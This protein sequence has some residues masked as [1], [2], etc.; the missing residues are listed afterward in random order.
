MAAF[1]LAPTDS[2]SA[3]CHTGYVTYRT[4][5]RIVWLLP[6]FLLLPASVRAQD[7]TYTTNVGAITITGY[8]GAGGDVVIPDTIDGLPVTDIGTRAFYGNTSLTSVLIPVSVTNISNSAF[9]AC[10]NLSL[11]QLGDNARTIG[12]GAFGFCWSLTNVTIP[13]CVTTIGDSA[14]LGCGGLTSV[15]IPK[16][17]V[18]IGTSAFRT[19]VQG[20]RSLTNIS[21]D[22][23]NP[24]Y[25]S[26][27]GVLFD[28]TQTILI[29]CP[30][31]K[32]GNYPIPDGVTDIGYDSFAECVK[33]VSITIPIGVTNIGDSAFVACGGLTSVSI[34]D[35]V[36]AIGNSAFQSCIGLTNVTIGNAVTT[37]GDSAFVNC[38]GLTS[39]SIPDSVFAIGTNVFVSC[40][41]L[42]DIEVN[43]A[44]PNFS[45]LDGVLFDKAEATLLLY[46]EGRVG[47]YEVPDSVATIGNSAFA[48]CGGLTD[49]TIPDSVTDIEDFAFNSCVG[50]MSMK[51]GENVQSI[52]SFAFFS[53]GNLASVTIPIN[54]TDIGDN[55]FT[56][57]QRLTS[58]YC[59][60]NAPSF[61]GLSAF[62]ADDNAT[63]YYLPGTTGWGTM[64]AGRPT[65]LWNPTPQ[66]TGPSNLFGFTITG[67]SNLVVVVEAATS[68]STPDWTPVGT[69]TLTDG[70]SSFNDSQWKDHPARFYRLRSP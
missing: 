42:T 13:D 28:K 37:I 27:D 5:M 22:A 59:L 52:G 26:L 68:L 6:L 67:T 58:V 21:V 4:I 39:V 3:T 54:V 53:C 35:S 1:V 51:I 60:G 62:I 9:Y 48:N 25:S 24:N 32:A 17:V 40:T 45:S 31:G 69:N 2:L 30:A 64:L 61:V 47:G 34:P 66:I 50:L 44:N 23:S 18:A 12:D 14:F 16:N 43:A 33:L 55:A 57:C 8:T 29:Q 38:G 36:I 10:R 11:L 49:I 63:V 70:S 15:A 56:F 20:G 19:S 46:P 7:F 65:V 41:R